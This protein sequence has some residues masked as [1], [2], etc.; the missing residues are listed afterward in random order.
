MKTTTIN[1]NK[2]KIWL[3]IQ[4]FFHYENRNGL[5]LVWNN[6]YICFFKFSE[7]TDVVL[8]ELILDE[9]K[10]VKLFKSVEDAEA[11]GIEYIEKKIR[12]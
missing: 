2:I 6:E 11:F 1:I 7:P 3:L 10:R 12:H 9:N 8:G 5:S 4:Q